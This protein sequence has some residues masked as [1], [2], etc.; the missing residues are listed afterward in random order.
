MRM[1]SVDTREPMPAAAR[2]RRRGVIWLVLFVVIIG[3]A[4]YAVWRVSRPASAATRTGAEGGGGRGGGFRGGGRGGG[5]G[6]LVPVVVTNASRSTIPVYLNG[7][8]T[9]TAY[10]TVTVKSRVDGQLMKVDFNEGDRVQQGQVLAEID[11]RPFQVQLQLA[12]AA[13][14]RDKALLTNAKLDVDRYS[15]LIERQL[16]PTQQLDTQ[17][18]LVEQYEATVKQDEANIESAKLQLVYSNVTAPINGMAGLRLVDPGNIVHAA[19]ATGMVVLTQLQPISVLFTIPEDS[20]PEVRR[21]LREGNHLPVEAY[22]RDDS[23][24]LASGTLATV[25]NEIDSSTGTSR[26]KAVFDNGD[27][28]LFPQ[29]FVNIHLLVDS[30]KN[31]LALPNVA[32][33]NGQNGTFVYVVDDQSH[34]HLRPVRVGI[35]TA[36]TAD[37]VSGIVDGDRVVVD[38]TDRL[39]EGAEVRVRT[40]A[41]AA[42]AMATD[43]GAGGK[44]RG[45]GSSPRRGG[46]GQRNSATH[47]SARGNSGS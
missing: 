16:I 24:K 2:P 42:A 30:L 17:A 40:A 45:D 21:K 35:T 11:Q 7:L 43:D 10:Y 15:H 33:Q 34:V 18:A 27:N 29:Q 5:A 46:D 23:K 12:Q 14:A 13:L 20:L 32:V 25:D 39:V 6:D 38:G 41:D 9:V 37:I 44:G 47:G 1:T 3:V 22:S 19:D 4:G 31:Q 36:T 8:G 28:A 26:L